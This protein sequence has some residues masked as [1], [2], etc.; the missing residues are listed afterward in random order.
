MSLHDALPQHIWDHIYDSLDF[1]SLARLRCVHSGMSEHFDDELIGA[2]LVKEAA[3]FFRH[4]CF[5]LSKLLN[6]D[7]IRKNIGDLDITISLSKQ[8]HIMFTYSRAIWGEDCFLF[9]VQHKGKAFVWKR[10]HVLDDILV[11]CCECMTSAWSVIRPYC[12]KNK[13]NYMIVETKMRG[14]YLILDMIKSLNDKRPKIL[15]TPIRLVE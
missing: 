1:T 14:Y 3:W 9:A 7:N 4:L 15:Q 12:V 6:Y 10:I 5:E 2:D 8:V 13:N 11:R